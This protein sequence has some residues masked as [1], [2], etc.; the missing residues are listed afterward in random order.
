MPNIKV[1]E[2]KKVRTEWD[3][4]KEDWLFSAADVCNILSDS[5]AKDKNA[6]WR[7]LKLR[8]KKEGSEVVSNCYELKLI[9]EDGKNTKPMLCIQKIY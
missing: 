9:A 1:F 5:Q 7:N 6:Y 3:S 8:L 4:E 2:N